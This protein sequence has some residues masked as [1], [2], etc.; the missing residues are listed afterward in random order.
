[1]R[2]CFKNSAR[3]FVGLAVLLFFSIPFGLSITGCHHAVAV[4]YCNAG[5]SGPVVGQVA[6]IT[7]SPSLATTG[8]SL[9]YGEIGSG[10]SASGLDCKGNAVS[11]TK[12]V[13]ATSNMQIVDINPSNGQTC[14]G[15]WNRNSGGGIADYTT[16][17][18]QV[19]SAAC[20]A[21]PNNTSCYLAYIT[22][23]AE[24]AV[25][26]AI[27]V[28][29]HPVVT[30]VVIGGA[31]PGA[32]GGSCPT[33]TS[34]PGTDCCPNITT[35][36]PIVAPVYTSGSCVSQGSV[37]QLVARIYANGSTTPANNITCQI[38]H[39]SFQ[40]QNSGNIVAIDENGVA[41]A[42]QPGSTIIS[43]LV[44]NS[45]SAISS[46]YFS[47]CPPASITLSLP[48]Q[49]AG[50]SS[51][52]VPINNA[53]P[54]TAVVKDTKGVTI[55]G[56]QLEYNSTTPQTIPAS[57]GS[58]TPLYPGT[59]TLTAVC[60]PAICNPS[61]FS[62]IGLYGNGKPITSNG[63]TV[64]AV[65]TS[66]TVIFMGSTSSQYVLPMDF[67]TNQPSALIKLPYLPNSMVITQD[68]NTVY[69]GSSSAL[70]SF[71]TLNNTQGTPNTTVTGTVISVSPDGTTLVVTD[72]VRQTISLYSPSSTSVNSSYG[73]IAT[74]AA[75]SPDSS[76][77]YITTQTGNLLLTHNSFTNWQVTP[78]TENYTA[79]AVTVPSI[80]AYFAGPSFTDGRS[81]CAA[82]TVN[83]ANTPPTVTNVFAPLAD[84]NASI[85]DTL[86]ST[87]DG[88]HILGATASTTPAKLNDLDLTLPLPTT[89][90]PNV[91]CPIPPAAQV[92]P[93]YF[94]S[95][96]NTVPLTS[97]T[98]T[99]IT[100]VVP[101]S[102]SKL[103]FVTYAGSSG[104]L[105]LYLP[106]ASGLGT[107]TYLTLG[108]GATTAAAPVS[109]VF[110]TDNL[111][112]YAGTGAANSNSVDNDVHIF[113]INGT[114]A[115]ETGIISPQL[116]LF[117]GNA[118]SAPVTFVVQKPKHLTN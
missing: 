23:T 30:G 34:D 85:N 71:T 62:Q 18:P 46:G 37:A 91:A 27:P 76:T 89:A 87:T 17:T 116:P 45:S 2:L 8:I 97:I 73:G 6:S 59:A 5:D 86:S 57:V 47:T 52:N 49:P 44:S 3:K 35:G 95:T 43:T 42:N 112:F 25:S 88:L 111:F 101:A 94:L 90:N 24:G 29:V 13:Y 108:N 54:I 1:M 81:Y 64:N 103:A 100:G 48:G 53:Q 102:N 14:G 12:V 60:N 51:I 22:A 69:L 113:S 68:G 106:P 32:S 40:A 21:A 36:T 109:G 93:G 38:G 96:T 79:V 66:G 50:T 105:P 28:Y 77:V 56:L 118:G 67:T 74:S 16:C 98:A 82:S 107:L 4:E 61:P 10:L 26:N 55:T 58:V 99:K 41:T 11:L 83:N 75:W 114:T 31:T 110:S 33:G 65:G 70:M 92:A 19:P 9:N 104:K 78:T 7:L 39:V 117:N 84:E 20:L 63:L 15:S 115:T 80:G 72:P